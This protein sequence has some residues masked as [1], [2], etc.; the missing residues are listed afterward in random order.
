MRGRPDLSQA[1]TN[2]VERT[3]LTVRTQLRRH[4]RRTNAHSKK[5]AAHQAAVALMVARD[6]FYRAHE[7]LYVTPAMEFGLTSQVW[8]V[9]ELLRAA[10]PTT[11]DPLP[12]PPPTLRPDRN[13]FRLRVV[14]GGRS[15]DARSIRAGGFSSS[16]IALEM[17]ESVK[18]G[19][20]ARPNDPPLEWRNLICP[21][22]NGEVSESGQHRWAR[23]PLGGHPLTVPRRVREKGG[24]VF[25]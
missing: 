15:V 18:M 17:D 2:P 20:L 4:T 23:I 5:L 11:L 1:T 7:P 8:R 12:S 25:P 21:N 14:R 10:P 16:S 3:N 19:V 13:S 22:F 24:E 6:N 9:A